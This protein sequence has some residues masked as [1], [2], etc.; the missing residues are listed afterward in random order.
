ML[1]NSRKLLYSILL[2][3]KQDMPLNIAV[4]IMP[5]TAMLTANEAICKDVSWHEM[6]KTGVK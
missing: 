4:K 1:P 5:L 6:G 3:G 2:T